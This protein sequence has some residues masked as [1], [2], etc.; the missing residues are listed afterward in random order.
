[1]TIP[2]ERRVRS[3]VLGGVFLGFIMMMFG[4]LPQPGSN[5]P[6]PIWIWRTVAWGGAA[7]AACTLPA[8]IA[9]REWTR[10]AAIAG[11]GLTTAPLGLLVTFSLLQGRINP[12]TVLLGAGVI[13]CVKGVMFYLSPE[14]RECFRSRS[15]DS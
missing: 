3:A 13:G 15:V 2:P 14:I 9:R 1:M 10:W 8:A 5:Q 4:F 11:M 6:L 12:F 7:L